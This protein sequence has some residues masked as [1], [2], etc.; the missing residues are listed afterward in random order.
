MK[1]NDYINAVL[2][3]VRCRS[4]HEPLKQ[5]LEA[6]ID[7]Q[8]E[9]FISVGL[10]E[11]EAE[12]ESVK[13]MG[14]AVETGVMLD[15]EHRPRFPLSAAVIALLLMLT[16]LTA[17][18]L[19]RDSFGFFNEKSLYTVLSIPVALVVMTACYFMDYTIFTKHPKIAY[20]CFFCILAATAY[21]RYFYRVF[22]RV[23]PFYNYSTSGRFF[24]FEALLL[25]PFTCGFVW[26]MRGKGFGGFVLTCILMV[27]PAAFCA[28]LTPCISAVIL[29]GLSALAIMTFAVKNNFFN[30]KKAGAYLFMYIPAGLSFISLLILKFG[31]PQYI[32]T[33]INPNIR[34]GFTADYDGFLALQ[35]IV[36]HSRLF[37]ESSD[38]FYLL[39]AP[40][41]D[42]LITAVTIRFGWAAGIILSLILISLPVIVLVKTRMIKNVFGRMT[43]FSV[44][45]VFLFETVS[46]ILANFG[47]TTIIESV[48]APPFMTAS[49]SNVVSS[50]A[51]LGIFMSAYRTK[52][53]FPERKIEKAL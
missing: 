38:P 22:D 13:T 7:D 23:I 3:Q 24:F 36:N 10:P 39:P 33:R 53:I 32:M 8:A 9:A 27:V 2:E 31:L 42:H 6:H 28:L 45:I 17:R 29:I 48:I 52:D 26:S 41:S 11:S 51:L 30:V 44:G 16:G 49:L 15:R 12:E 50:A 1:K 18:L 14:D 19:I 47:I 37:G 34:F 43:S 21:L 35:T 5:E 40:Q 20:I 25:A 4:A 46:Y